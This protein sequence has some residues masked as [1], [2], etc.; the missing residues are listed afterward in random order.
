MIENKC[1]TKITMA[2]WRLLW[3]KVVEIS[4]KLVIVDLASQVA[5]KYMFSVKKGISYTGGHAR[6]TKRNDS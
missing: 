5:K 3:R 4:S 2:F 1:N 6:H